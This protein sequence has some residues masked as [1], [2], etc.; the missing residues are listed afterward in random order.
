MILTALYLPIPSIDKVSAS[1]LTSGSVEFGPILHPPLLIV[2][3]CLVALIVR[4]A[5]ISIT[6]RHYN[7]IYQLYSASVGCDIFQREVV[8][9]V[10]VVRQEHR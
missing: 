1:M 2:N 10:S 3:S 4:I 7:F 5:S 6:P 9:R 8:G